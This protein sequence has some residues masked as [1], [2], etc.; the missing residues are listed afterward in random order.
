MLAFGRLVR[1]RNVTTLTNQRLSVKSAGASV[2]G[3]NGHC[4]ILQEKSSSTADTGH[5]NF[6]QIAGWMG[7]VIHSLRIR[8]RPVRQ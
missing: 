2:P 6:G 8:A 7:P 1:C 3:I 5:C 4:G